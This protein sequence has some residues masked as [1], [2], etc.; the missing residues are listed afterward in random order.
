MIRLHVEFQIMPRGSEAG[1][2][3]DE[4]ADGIG[5]NAVLAL[6]DAI[7]QVA[8]KMNE[9]DGFHMIHVGRQFEI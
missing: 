6:I 9:T 1:E 2:E 5:P 3:R 8:D 7:V 4:S